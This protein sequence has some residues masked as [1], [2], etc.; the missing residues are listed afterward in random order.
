VGGEL[1]IFLEEPSVMKVKAIVTLLVLVCLSSCAPLGSGFRIEGDTLACD[2]PK[3]AIHL[4]KAIA[5]TQEYGDCRVITFK[6][7]DPRPMA[8]QFYRV[9]HS[10]TIDYFNSLSEIASNMNHYQVG[11]VTFGGTEW[12]KTAFFDK[13]DCLYCGY[14]TRKDNEFI[15]IAICNKGIGKD[16]REAFSEYSRTLKMSELALTIIDKQFDYFNE[17]AEIRL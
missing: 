7:G 6:G 11:T 5:S 12:L 1:F 15:Y 8:I 16:G 4:K 14:F 17:V 9:A 10:T 2:R 13:K 3:L